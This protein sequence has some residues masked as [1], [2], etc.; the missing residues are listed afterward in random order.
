MEEVEL[1]LDSPGMKEQTDDLAG[2]QTRMPGK[3]EST[4]H[5][6]KRGCFPC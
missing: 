2:V 4:S 5:S 6:D 3:P 1:D